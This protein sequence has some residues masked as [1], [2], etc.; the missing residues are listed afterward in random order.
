MVTRRFLSALAWL[1]VL[2][3]AAADQLRPVASSFEAEGHLPPFSIKLG[4]DT[5]SVCNSTTPG[6][7]GFIKSDDGTDSLMELGPCRIAHEGG[8]TVDNPYGWNAN[9]SVIF[10]LPIVATLLI[11][12][13][14]ISQPVSVGFSRGNA[15]LEGLVDASHL[16]HRFLRQFFTAFP[17]LSHQDF[18]ISGES[19]GD[20]WVPALGAN[21]AKSQAEGDVSGYLDNKQSNLSQNRMSNPTR[22][23][24]IN[25]K[26]IMLGN[27][28]I[29]RSVQNGGG[30]ETACSGPGSLFNSTTCRKWAP[31]ALWCEQNLDVCGTQGW[32]SDYVTGALGRNPYD[33]RLPCNNELECYAEM[34]FIDEYLNRTDIKTS[35]GV[36]PDARFNG[37]S[38]EVLNQW[39]QNGDLWKSSDSYVNY[40]LDANYRV[41][42]YVG[43]KYWYCN[44]AGMRRL[45]NQGLNWHGHPL[46][47]FRELIP[48]YTGLKPAGRWKAYEPLTYAE[49]VDT[50]HLAP[51]D[52][53]EE[54]LTLIN[55]WIQGSLPS[56]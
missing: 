30:L 25:L 20:S 41:L 36:E 21:I 40:L 17:K 26:G 18:Y 13:R 51:F 54:T 15:I 46:F 5:A 33:F 23:S 27:G 39:Q 1:K 9:A 14:I 34:P 8:Y 49:V 28:L 4:N 56:H 31:R 55:S 53:P 37:V 45:V 29:R 3:V 43:D 35:L 52:K 19:Y 47:R 12:A 11:E 16:M 32:T 7:A 24:T 44:A 2:S 6:T 38:L 48:W 42:I 22:T 50:G 10:L